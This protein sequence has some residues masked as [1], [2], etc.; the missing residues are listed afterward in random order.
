MEPRY[1]EQTLTDREFLQRWAEEARGLQHEQSHEAP[2][3]SNLAGGKQSL[4]TRD[5]TLIPPDALAQV[6]RVM[7]NGAR[8]YAKDNWRLIS[9]NDHLNH[10]LNHIYLHCANNTQEDH[11]S[12]ATT[13]LLMAL[14]L[15]LLEKYDDH[16][17]D[18]RD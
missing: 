10:A 16:T 5:F 12:H 8:K 11:L 9:V 6:A 14:D 3:T 2:T 4:L 13:R 15:Q 17:N 7:Y 18:H 1:M